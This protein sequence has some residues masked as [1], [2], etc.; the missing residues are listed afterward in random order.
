MIGILAL[1]VA[2]T[3][4]SAN[5]RHQAVGPNVPEWEGGRMKRGAF[6]AQ[7]CK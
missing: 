3:R 2:G 5:E 1:S 7:T 4:Q 6:L